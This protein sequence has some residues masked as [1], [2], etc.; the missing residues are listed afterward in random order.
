M[1]RAPAAASQGPQGEP[2]VVVECTAEAVAGALHIFSSDQI[3]DETLGVPSDRSFQANMTARRRR[4]RRP[5]RFHLCPAARCP[6]ASAP[7]SS[8][9]ISNVLHATTNP[10]A[11]AR[12]SSRL[13]AR[14][15]STSGEAAGRRSSARL[16]SRAQEAPGP[17]ST[18]FWCQGKR[19]WPP[20]P[21]TDLLVAA[22]MISSAA[23]ARASAPSRWS[24][25]ASS[26][27][28]GDGPY[29]CASLSRRL[30]LGP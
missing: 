5:G 22:R 28:N 13:Q 29:F 27:A 11:C 21:P 2:R 15:A 8:L 14:S 4:R 17:I 24:A 18:G 3:E 6:C 1:R 30:N 20:R 23:S 26:R 25:I 9:L 12:A 16:A 10:T 7:R 19:A